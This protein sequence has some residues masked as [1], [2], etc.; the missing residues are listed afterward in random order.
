MEQLVLFSMN[1]VL[2]FSLVLFVLII[3]LLVF[4][5]NNTG[6]SNSVASF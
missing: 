6:K 1:A 5:L 4:I 3:V 2:Q